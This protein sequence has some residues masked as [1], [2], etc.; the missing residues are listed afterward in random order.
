MRLILQINNISI[1]TL[2]TED[3]GD[4]V[5][6]T[7]DKIYMALDDRRCA[8]SEDGIVEVALYHEDGGGLY[9]VRNQ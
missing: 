4:S 3:V 8:A 2:D 7:V 9:Y 5:E 6:E 1:T